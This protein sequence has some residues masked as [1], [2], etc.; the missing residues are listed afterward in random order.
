MQAHWKVLQAVIFY[1]VANSSL[2][3]GRNF[4]SSLLQDMIWTTVFIKPK[5]KLL[6]SL[7]Y[8]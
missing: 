6:L 7:Y 4:Y 5:N 1:G 3:C 8:V 2:I